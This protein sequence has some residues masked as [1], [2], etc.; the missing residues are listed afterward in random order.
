M[1][2][3]V[4]MLAVL[5]AYFVDELQSYSVWQLGDSVISCIIQ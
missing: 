5:V 2:R 1:V 4:G 3:Y